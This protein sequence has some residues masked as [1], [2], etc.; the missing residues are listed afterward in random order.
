MLKVADLAERA[1]K[2][3]SQGATRPLYRDEI[4]YDV[5]GSV[6]VWL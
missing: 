6:G 2:S 1:K 3:T 4:N 5:K